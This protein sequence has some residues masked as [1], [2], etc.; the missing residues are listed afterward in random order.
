MFNTSWAKVPQ[1]ALMLSRSDFRFSPGLGRMQTP[2][3]RCNGNS[4]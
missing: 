1:I 3:A 2:R 4:E